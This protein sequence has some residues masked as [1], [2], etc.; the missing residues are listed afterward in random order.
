MG[1]SADG[2][3]LIGQ[4]PGEEDLYIAASFQG[5]GMVLC[6]QSAIALSEIISQDDEAL[7]RWFP[8]AFRVTHER[9]KRKFR[10]RLHAKV[11]P[12]DL[13]VKSQL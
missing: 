1:Y 3:P 11:S 9:M 5:S 13:E 10:G 12:M 6:F 7:D 2:F 4:M 8:K